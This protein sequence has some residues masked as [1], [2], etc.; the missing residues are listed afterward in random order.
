MGSDWIGE[1]VASPLWCLANGFVDIISSSSRV[2]S[3][4]YVLVAAVDL[5]PML[6]EICLDTPCSSVTVVVGLEMSMMVMSL[7]LLIFDGE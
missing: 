6:D 4:A 7:L 2:I 3:V 5:E 1:C